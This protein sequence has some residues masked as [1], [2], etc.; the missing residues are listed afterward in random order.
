M[1]DMPKSF[2]SQ[3]ICDLGLYPNFSQVKGYS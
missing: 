1:T 2:V 3:I